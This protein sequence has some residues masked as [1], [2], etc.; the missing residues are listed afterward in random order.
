MMFGRRRLPLLLT[1]PLL[2]PAQQFDAVSIR[3]NHTGAEGSDTSTTTGRLTLINAT[4]LS[5]V[6]R[7]FGVQ[8]HQVVGAP[9]WIATERYDIVAVTGGA[10]RLTDKE[11]QPFIRALLTDRFAFKY[12]EETREL[13]V[14]SLVIAKGGA[15]LLPGT[16][17][18]AMKLTAESGKQILRSN[19]GNI[20]RLVEILSRVTGRM[21]TDQSGLSAQYDFTL[22]WVPDQEG[23]AAGPS[24]FTALQEQLGLKLEPAKVPAKVIVIDRIERPSEN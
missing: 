16:G 19:K 7:A 17:E 20:P 18:Y 2:L 22:S 24:L 21:V 9:A 23:D 5:L 4:P 11:R 1:L 3:P 13:R 15:K 10:D 6:W 14:W 12:H 8:N